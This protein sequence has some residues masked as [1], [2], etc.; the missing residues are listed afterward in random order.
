MTAERM[1]THFVGDDCPGGHRDASPDPLPERAPAGR[2]IP[3][4][5]AFTNTGTCSACSAPLS[6]CTT[7]AGKRAPL[8][9]DGTSHFADCPE[10]GRFR[11]TR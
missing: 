6:W 3:E 9:P 2:V 7:K 1:V 10:A 11:R 8:N 5:Y 4:G